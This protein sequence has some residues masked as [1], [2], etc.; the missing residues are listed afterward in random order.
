MSVTLYDILGIS[1][2]SS[3]KDIRQAYLKKAISEHPD[4]GGSSESFDALQKA[5]TILSNVGERAA[6]DEKVF[7]QRDVGAVD[8]QTQ[9][10][11]ANNYYRDGIKVEFHGQ[12]QAPVEDRGFQKRGDTCAGQVA[13]SLEEDPLSRYNDSIESNREALI[14]DPRNRQ[15]V[16]N[17]AASYIGRAVYHM[18]Q[19]KVNH[20][21]FDIQEAELVCPLSDIPSLPAESVQNIKDKYMHHMML[22]NMTDEEEDDDGG[23]T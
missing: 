8:E 13:N 15:H 17:L 16:Q 22:N 2:D 5:Y 12:R 18:S 19:N 7:G 6:Y 10:N 3:L 23:S 1:R 4:K 20:A 11:Y 9:Y 14:K 21:M